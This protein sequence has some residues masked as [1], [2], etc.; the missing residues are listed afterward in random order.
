VEY[1][2]NNATTPVAPEVLETMLPYFR[3]RFYNP[4]AIS[5]HI[6]RVDRDIAI[7]RRIIAEFLGAS[8]P[9]EIT[10]TS[11]ATESCNWAIFGSAKAN[12]NRRHIITSKVEHPAVLEP[13]KQLEKEGYKVTYISVDCDGNLDIDEL[14]ASIRSN[15]LLV[16]LMAAN[17][18]TGVIFPIDEVSALVKER[19]P[20]IVFHTDATQYVGKLPVYLGDHFR[21]VDLLSF[22]GHKMYAPKGIGGLFIRQGLSIS[23]LIMGG[24]Q[25][26][27]RRSGTENVAYIIGLAAACPIAYRV[28]TEADTIEA[29]RDRLQARLEQLPISVSINC[30]GTHRLPNTLSVAFEG[31][32]SLTL[33][34]VLSQK[35]IYASNGS[36]C[37]S[38]SEAPSHVLLA[39][40]LPYDQAETTIRFSLGGSTITDQ[41]ISFVVDCIDKI[42]A[43][44]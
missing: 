44:R 12:P 37:S 31:I 9:S 18:E 15:T 42:T 16:T 11:G 30:L 10:F 28:I 35:G 14:S 22:S 6:F 8:E 38:G 21:N 25:E 5:G 41:D 39:M 23:S 17:N 2:D 32:D 26:F 13:C 27:G 20:E 40:G 19:D 24:G 1:L 29:T 4:S 36:A 7:A 33:L 43:G 3:E 34:E